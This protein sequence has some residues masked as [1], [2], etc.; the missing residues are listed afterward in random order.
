MMANAPGPARLDI[1]TENVG[2]N[3]RRV[4]ARDLGATVIQSIF[5]LAKQATLHSLD[6]QAVVRQVEETSHIINDYGQRTDQNVSIL[7]SFGSIFVGGQLLKAS[8]Q[9]YEGAVEL[10]ELLKK[11]GYSEIAIARNV[12]PQDLFAFV[13]AVA[14]AQRASNGR[15]LE[16]PSPRI[17][18]RAVGEAALKRGAMVERL[19][20]TQAV[21]RMYSSAI[22]IMRRFFEQ[23]QRGKYELPQRV[24]RIAQMLVDLSRGKR[25]PS[26]E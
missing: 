22:V 26:S 1:I 2:E 23:L 14:E 12:N 11:F 18:M 19:D 4:Q 10:G 6:N 21:V 24:K 13:S 20:E 9:V 5:R 25:R 7:F 16:K 8:R 15:G 17:R 3:I